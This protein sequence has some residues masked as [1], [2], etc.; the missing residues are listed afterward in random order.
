LDRQSVIPY[1]HGEIVV[2]LFVWGCS[3]LSWTY[4]K[5]LGAV[6]EELSKISGCPIPL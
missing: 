3:R 6:S 5:E 4:L 1:V 2:L